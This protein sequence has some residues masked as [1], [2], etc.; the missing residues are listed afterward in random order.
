MP[1][2]IS[3]LSCINNKHS[4]SPYPQ[5]PNTRGRRLLIFKNFLLK[6]IKLLILAK[7]CPRLNEIFVQNFVQKVRSH[8]SVL[9]L[10][11]FLLEKEVTAAYSYNVLL[12]IVVYW[13]F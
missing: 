10:E 12:L 13:F 6:L 3:L 8:C 2:L 4:H 11:C 7:Q 9:I 5:V 1:G